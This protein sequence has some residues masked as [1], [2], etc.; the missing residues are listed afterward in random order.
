MF[1][2]LPCLIAAAALVAGCA[3]F[4]APDQA[5]AAQ[6]R[7]PY[8]RLV[9]VE[10]LKMAAAPRPRSATPTALQAAATAPAAGIESRAARLK[11]RAAR[12]RRDEVI[13]EQDRERLD[14][15][16]EIPPEDV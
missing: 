4:P 3:D 2:R 11:A 9:P 10:M 13:D 16:V 1:V 14:K 6:T 5:R 7:S 15:P 12:L 8:P